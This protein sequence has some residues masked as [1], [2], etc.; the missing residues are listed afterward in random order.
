MII[1]DFNLLFFKN[2]KTNPEVL[3][4]PCVSFKKIDTPE[5]D[6]KTKYNMYTAVINVNDMPNKLERRRE[7]NVRDAK[8]N[9]LVAKKISES[10][11]ENPE[12]FIY[13]NRWLTIIANDVSYDNK[14]WKMMLDLKNPEKHGLLDGWHTFRVIQ[15]YTMWWERGYAE[16]AYVKLEII[17]WVKAIDDIADIVEARNTSTQVKDESIE[18]LKWWFDMIHDVLDWTYYWPEIHYQE[19]E[20]HKD[21]LWDQDAKTIDIKDILSYLICL[22]TDNYWIDNHPVK[23]YS[24]RKWVMTHYKEH[25]DGLQKF[26]NLL[27]DI[28]ELYDYIY[29]NLPKWHNDNGWKFWN[30]TGIRTLSE[31]KQLPYTD[32]LKTWYVIPKGFIYPI[33]AS[34]RGLV[35]IENWKAKWEINPKKVLDDMWEILSRIVVEQATVHNNPNKLWKDRALWGSCHREVRIY[36]LEQVIKN[37]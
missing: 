23:A 35:T 9:N 36:K 10:L 16:E 34:M 20:L 28:I 21:R 1:R 13:K 15:E 11:T 6:A 26:I 5:L 27:P 25:K 2:M 4:V 24:S 18:E 12:M 37:R 7:I 19:Y 14:T 22:D 17:T 30:L 32:W 3:R 29:Y 33:L 31:K 8:L